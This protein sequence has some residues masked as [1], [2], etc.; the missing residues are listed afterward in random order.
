[1]SQSLVL[2]GLLVYFSNE[3]RTIYLSTL[4]FGCIQPADSYPD[5][6]HQTVL[7]ALFR[8]TLVKMVFLRVQA[9]AFG[10]DFCV[11][12][13]SNAEEAVLGVDSIQSA[14]LARLHPSDIVA[15]GANLIASF[16]IALPAE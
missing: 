8:A 16:L 1:M 15:D 11:G 12:T 4:P 5:F 7:S 3:F 9:S 10:L 13:G 2:A 14:V 6:S